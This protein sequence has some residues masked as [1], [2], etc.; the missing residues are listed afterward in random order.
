MAHTQKRKSRAVGENNKSE[1]RMCAQQRG[2]VI[3][4]GDGGVVVGNDASSV[5]QR[6]V[7]GFHQ[8]L[9]D[10]CDMRGCLVRLVYDLRGWTPQ[11]ECCC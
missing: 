3:H 9:Q 6:H 10:A 8:A 4:T 11:K 5:G 7:G 1:I 2:L